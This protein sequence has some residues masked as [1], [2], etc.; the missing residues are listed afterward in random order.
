MPCPDAA[1]QQPPITHRFVIGSRCFH[2][3]FQLPTVSCVYQLPY[4]PPVHP[5]QAARAR[6]EYCPVK[7]AESLHPH[8]GAFWACDCANV[9]FWSANAH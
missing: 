7:G 1:V 9:L 3:Q 8:V 5:F 2:G 6:K 4:P